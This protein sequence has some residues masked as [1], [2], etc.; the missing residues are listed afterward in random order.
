MDL[1]EF[2]LCSGTQVFSVGDLNTRSG[3]IVGLPHNFSYNTVD[4]IKLSEI[5][6][7]GVNAEQLEP[8]SESAEALNQ[9]IQ[10]LVLS[11]NA[12]KF[13]ITRELHL[14]NNDRVINGMLTTIFTSF[15][16]I[17]VAQQI[18]LSTRIR[19]RH[20]QSLGLRL[21]FLGI[22]V[23]LYLVVREMCY[24]S[25]MSSA[26][27]AAIAQGEAYYDGAV[28]YYNKLLQREQALK[29][30]RAGNKI[31]DQTITELALSLMDIKGVPPK[32]CLE[33]VYELNPRA[34]DEDEGDAMSSD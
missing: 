26:D 8:D 1:M 10:S 9:L 34:D 25:W 7:Y 21:V 3:A 13:A 6:I 31:R 16:G 5:S 4:D 24:Y 20:F 11:E 33:K 28:E 17:G 23:F 22:G 18:I 30:L 2:F 27:K 14:C 15:L 12:K 29:Q 19:R 32:K